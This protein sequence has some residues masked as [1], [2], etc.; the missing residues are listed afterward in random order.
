MSRS[1]AVHTLA[2]ELPRMDARRVRLLRPDLRDPDVAKRLPP[3][4]SPT[5]PS[6]SPLTLAMRPVGALIFG[7]IADRYGRRLPLMLDVIFYSI[8]EVLS[9][10]APDLRHASCSSARCTASAWAANGASAPRSRWKRCRRA[11]R[12]LLSGL[13]QEGYAVGYLLAAAAYFFIFPALRMARAVL[14]RRHRPRCS[15]FISAPRFPNPKRG[16]ASRP[17]AGRDLAR[18]IR[19][20]FGRFVYLVALMTMMNLDLA[21]HPGH[22]SDLPRNRA[23][24]RSAH[25]SRRSRSSTMSA[26]LLGG[27]V[28][29]YLSDRFGPAP[30]DGRR[31]CCWRRA[32]RAVLDLSRIR[33]DA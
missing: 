11:A 19:R 29:G 30:L 21:R 25:W 18:A 32:H 7:W 6:P 3:L 26:R 4:A 17:T 12:G 8:V 9:G 1:D 20:N 16:N 31:R 14:P 27:L 23:R 2:R 28:F 24:P 33:F 15:R 5:S 22:V 10:L 13:L